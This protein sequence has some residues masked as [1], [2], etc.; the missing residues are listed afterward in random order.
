MHG[1]TIWLQHMACSSPAEPTGQ[2]ALSKWYVCVGRLFAANLRLHQHAAP[3]VFTYINMQHRRQHGCS[4][5]PHQRKALA[6]F[7]GPTIAASAPAA[8]PPPPVLLT[9]TH[10]KKDTG[11]T[12]ES[13]SQQMPRP[14]PVLGPHQCNKDKRSTPPQAHGAWKCTHHQHGQNERH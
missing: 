3:P 1:C 7:L 5:P 8:A 14:H 11:N 9:C 4:I 6:P 10:N 13:G 2:L 12:M